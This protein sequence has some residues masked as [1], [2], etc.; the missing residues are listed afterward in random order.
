MRPERE[1]D[2]AET[3]F[4]VTEQ[5]ASDK[6]NGLN[7]DVSCYRGSTVQWFLCCVTV[8]QFLLKLLNGN[9]FFLFL[10]HTSII[11]TPVL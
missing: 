11:R 5:Y 4:R 10:V 6:T 8:C 7:N 3:C 2:L 9:D 1:P